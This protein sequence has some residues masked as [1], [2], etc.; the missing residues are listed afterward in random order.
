MMGQAFDGDG[1][2]LGGAYGETKREVF[3][4][5]MQ[6]HPEAAEIRIKTIQDTLARERFE[7]DGGGSAQTPMPRYQSHKKVW[8]FKIADVLDPTE[9][10]KDSDGSR[11]IVPAEQ[12]YAPFRVDAAYV[13]KHNPQPGGYYVQYE[14]GYSSF[15]P[16]AAF[17]SGYTRL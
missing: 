5:L 16:A 9:D 17:E 15:S 8:A 13:R 14:D 1:N 2:V 7:R 12:G 3:D 6:A 10:G 11:L 4:K